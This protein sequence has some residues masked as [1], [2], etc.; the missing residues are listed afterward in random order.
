MRSSPV[1][2]G[3]RFTISDPQARVSIYDRCGTCWGDFEYV[4]GPLHGLK[5]LDADSF[6]ILSVP[7]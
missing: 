2:S 6:E 1:D 5:L 7:Q 4:R 3:L